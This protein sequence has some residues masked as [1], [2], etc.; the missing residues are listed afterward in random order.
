MKSNKEVRAELM[1]E[2][3]KCK[4]VS[5]NG[6]TYFGEIEV[7]DGIAKITNAIEWNGSV[8]ETAKAWLK[9]FNSFNLTSM[10]IQGNATY[11]TRSLSEDQEEAVELVVMACAK[12]AANALTDLINSKF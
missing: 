12:A 11:A 5:V 7:K 2:I 6:E 1:A 9:G 4:I 3:N 10:E 8:E